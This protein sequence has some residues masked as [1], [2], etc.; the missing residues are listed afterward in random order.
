MK[1]S[2]IVACVAAVIAV[3]FITASATRAATVTNGLGQVITVSL[4]TEGT[5]TANQE[6]LKG[7]VRLENLTNPDLPT[8]GFLTIRGTNLVFITTMK[9]G[10]AVAPTNAYVVVKAGVLVP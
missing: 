3:G 4:A 8:A 5:G 1:K 6:Y 9:D 10:V 2:F 7:A